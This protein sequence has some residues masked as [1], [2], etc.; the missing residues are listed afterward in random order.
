MKQTFLICQYFNNRES[1]KSVWRDLIDCYRLGSDGFLPAER[2]IIL[3]RNPDLIEYFSFH[4]FIG[5]SIC[6]KTNI[7]SNS[8]WYEKWNKHQFEKVH[9]FARWML[10]RHVTIVFPIKTFRKPLKILQDSSRKTLWQNRWKLCLVIRE[11]KVENWEN[12][13]ATHLIIQTM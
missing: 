3:S 1:R 7:T 4:F 12:I 9:L 8:G 13:V 5:T 10:S 11:R 6:N 2:F